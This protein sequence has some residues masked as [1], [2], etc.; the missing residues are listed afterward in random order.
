MA[1]PPTKRDDDAGPLENQE[2][3]ADK[4]SAQPQ[5]LDAVKNPNALF[6]GGPAD[7]RSAQ[8]VPAETGESIPSEA[9][10][11]ANENQTGVE[12]AAAQAAEPSLEAPSAAAEPLDEPPVGMPANLPVDSVPDALQP[13]DLPQATD[14]LTT[15]TAAENVALESASISDGLDDIADAATDEAPTSD[16]IGSEEVSATELEHEAIG[17][18]QPPAAIDEAGSETVS[19]D[20]AQPLY[21]ESSSSRTHAQTV[22][23]RT[24]DPPAQIEQ[25][26]FHPEKDDA[27]IEHAIEYR[28]EP[29]PGQAAQWHDPTFEV[30]STLGQ[31]A[32]VFVIVSLAESQVTQ[33]IDAALG[34]SAARDIETLS[35][36]AESVVEH[37]FWLRTCHER[38]LNG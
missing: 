13:A 19:T 4:T 16:L 9:A 35:E 31:V 10:G 25:L 15:G 7:E 12:R 30:G 17:E 5:P 8:Q 23:I 32:P 29:E 2:Q 21:P 3:G 38:A 28:H 27:Q 34:K 11:Q 22:E 14:E 1:E 33:L 26:P 6:T 37:A 36:L 18:L 20:S 24:D